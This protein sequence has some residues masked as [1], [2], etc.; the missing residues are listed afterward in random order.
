MNSRWISRHHQGWRDRVAR[1]KGG[2]ADGIAGLAPTGSPLPASRNMARPATG[3]GSPL[4]LQGQLAGGG[5]MRRNLTC[6]DFMPNPGTLAA[7]TALACVPSPEAKSAIP[8]L[9]AP[10][11]LGIAR[12]RP[13][14]YRA[15]AAYLGRPGRQGVGV[16]GP[17]PCCRIKAPQRRPHRRPARRGRGLCRPF[18]QRRRLN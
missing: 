4:R 13:S 10:L 11:C 16:S 12:S 14:P 7:A 2:A 9:R 18:P 3:P 6:R 15:K 1:S 17:G 8:P 5:E